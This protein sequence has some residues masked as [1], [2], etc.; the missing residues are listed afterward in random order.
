MLQDVPHSVPGAAHF[1][2]LFSHYA[3]KQKSTI[4]AAVCPWLQTEQFKEGFTGF[5]YAQLYLMNISWGFLN[6]TVF[7]ITKLS[8]Y[9]SFCEH[10]IAMPELFSMFCADKE[11]LFQRRH[12]IPFGM[13]S[14]CSPTIF[15][16]AFFFPSLLHH[17]LIPSLPPSETDGE[18]VV[19][20]SSLLPREGDWNAL[21]SEN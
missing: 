19:L 8:L 9:K 10:F 4:S 21:C 14:C 5:F 6:N 20:M 15:L 16:F 7:K 3:S 2:Y 12:Y 18:L 11:K 1:H 13:T 17:I